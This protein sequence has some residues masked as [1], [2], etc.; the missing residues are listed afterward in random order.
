M[1]RINLIRRIAAATNAE[2]LFVTSIGATLDDFWNYRHG[3]NVFFTTVLGSVTSTALGLALVLPHRRIIAIESDG[4]VLMNTGAMCTLG[5]ERPG[6][7]TVVV[8]DNGIYENIGGHRTHTSRGTDLAAMARG[9]GCPNAL[10]AQEEQDFTAS[11]QSMLDDNQLG[12]IVARVAPGVY[13]WPA[14]KKKRTDGLEDKY[15][16]LRYVENLEGTRS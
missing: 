2:D 6:N 9:A 10:S 5:A 7:L 13:P 1:Q 15:R 12:Y 16:F 4:S 11:F 14:E 8:I 3:D